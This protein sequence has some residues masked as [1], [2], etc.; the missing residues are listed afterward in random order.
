MANFF[1]GKQVYAQSWNVV[2]TRKFTEEEINAVERATIVPSTYGA[3]V[4]FFMNGGGRI[5]TPLSNDAKATV[6][7]NIDLSKAKI[8]TLERQGDGQIDRI[9]A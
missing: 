4:C 3:S 9:R 6:G 5:Y 8:I 7:E 2:G 1:S